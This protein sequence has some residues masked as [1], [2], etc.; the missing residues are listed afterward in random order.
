MN[1]EE[2]VETV[3]GVFAVL[4]DRDKHGLLTLAAEDIEWITPGEGWPMAGTH[5][6]HAGLEKLLQKANETV[7]ISFPQR[8]EFIRRETGFSS[9]ALQPEKLKSRRRRFR[10]TGSSTSLLKKARS[11]KSASMSTRKPL[12]GRQRLTRAIG[13]D[14]SNKLY[15]FA[16]IFSASFDPGAGVSYR[17]SA[18]I[19]VSRRSWS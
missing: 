19:R 18:N 2:N 12:L 16:D 15:P 3:K 8:P 4:G 11:R 14:P 13:A 7:E 17:P 1:I 5:R 10:T 9:S 6:G